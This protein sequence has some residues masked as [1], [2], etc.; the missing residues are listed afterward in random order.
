MPKAGE[1]NSKSN[2]FLSWSGLLI[3]WPRLGIENGITKID[4][5]LYPVRATLS[6]SI[7]V[8]VHV[9]VLDI[10]HLLPVLS[11]SLGYAVQ[12]A[13]KAF[14]V[15]SRQGGRETRV[16]C[17]FIGNVYLHIGL[18]PF[19]SSEIWGGT[20]A[21]QRWPA[22]LTFVFFFFFLLCRFYVFTIA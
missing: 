7:S 11:F 14:L 4:Y 13:R 9:H 8:H 15:I 6:F 18:C 22:F 10:V 1:L 16:D 20:G 3:Y 12:H 17:S 19:V 21:W 5:H 2:H